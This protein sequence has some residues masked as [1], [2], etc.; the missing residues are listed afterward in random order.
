MLLVILSSGSE[1]TIVNAVNP[2]WSKWSTW[3]CQLR[4]ESDR[5][6]QE[7]S[8]GIYFEG[9]SIALH[10]LL[11]GKGVTSSK[12]QRSC[13]QDNLIRA[14][15]RQCDRPSTPWKILETLLELLSILCLVVSCPLSNRTAQMF[16]ILR[17]LTPLYHRYHP[18]RQALK[19]PLSLEKR[20]IA[21]TNWITFLLGKV[22]PRMTLRF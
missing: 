12:T 6:F 22:R 5:S 18:L 11:V 2:Y 13:R 1:N 14:H 9:L 19:D 7:L 8:H 17:K 3:K 10:P 20:K 15:V 4:S 16:L 21:V